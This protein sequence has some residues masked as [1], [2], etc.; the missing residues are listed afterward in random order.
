MTGAPIPEGADAVVM[1][2]R[3]E[4][5]GAAQ[6]RVRLVAP[7]V[8]VGQNIMPRAASMARGERVLAAGIELRAIE[9]GVLAEIGRAHV[10]VVPRPKVAILATGNELVPLEV[11]PQVGHIRNSNSPMLAAAVHA[12]GALGIEVGIARDDAEELRKMIAFGLE[13]DVLVICGGVSAGVLDLVPGVLEASGVRQVFHKVN[14]KPGKP[15]WFGVLAADSGAK[16]VFGLPGNPVSSLVCFELFVRPAIA[17]LADRAE[18]ALAETTA[19]LTVPFTHRGERPTYHPARLAIVDG[20]QT[21][22]PA[23]WRGSGDLAALV[24]TNAL[25]CF[26]SGDRVYQPGESIR[27][28]RLP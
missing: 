4:L 17:R 13:H 8:G 25:A 11:M 6:D 10:R 15:L 22:E 21:V 23:R 24:G 26:P 12:A 16:L 2:E 27:V 20:Q 1:I 28:L 18:G 5:V 7:N 19:R 14:L 9:I 3:S